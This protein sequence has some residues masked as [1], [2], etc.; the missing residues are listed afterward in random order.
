[1]AQISAVMHGPVQ[2]LPSASATMVGGHEGGC[3]LQDAVQD[4]PVTGT[5]PSGLQSTLYG[6]PANVHPGHC[7]QGL[8]DPSAAP[9][10]AMPPAQCSWT[11]RPQDGA[12]DAQPS[13]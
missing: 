10:E 8:G 13:A 12:S 4:P 7:P 3:D 11:T 5:H 1:M 2:Q 9:H 6:Q